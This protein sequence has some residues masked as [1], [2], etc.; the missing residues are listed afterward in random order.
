MKFH[1]INK[2]V[3]V[4]LDLT[5][6]EFFDVVIDCGLDFCPEDG[7]YGSGTGDSLEVTV[8]GK[9]VKASTVK[10]T[11]IDGSEEGAGAACSEEK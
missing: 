9:I 1:R 11:I 4:G 3:A 10:L 6:Q 2:K 7:V 8:G 5:L